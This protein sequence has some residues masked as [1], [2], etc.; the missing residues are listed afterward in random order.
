MSKSTEELIEEF[1]AN[2]GEIEKLEPVVP[3]YKN[4]VGSTANKV[5]TL[6]TLPEGELMFGRKQVKKKKVKVPD[7]SHINMDLIPEH[8]KKLLKVNETKVDAT[9]EEQLETNQNL[10]SIKTSN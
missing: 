7:Y 9:K 8:L 2:G 3:E 1:L 4:R 6:M 5:P 10:G